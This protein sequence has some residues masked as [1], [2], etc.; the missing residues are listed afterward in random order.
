[1]TAICLSF[2]DDAQFGAALSRALGGTHAEL[3]IHCFPDGESSVR[4][5]ASCAG[6][7][8]I[9][10]GGGRD[11]NASALPLLFAAD[12]ARAM[13]AVSVGLAAPYLPYMRQDAE[14]LPG[15]AVSARA[16]ARFL[17]GTYD[18]IATVD[19]HLHRIQSLG[20]IF[21]IPA[22]C[23]SSMPAV[24]DWIAGNVVDPVIVGPDSESAQWVESVARA[25]AAPWTALAKIRTGDREVSV[26][27]PDPKLI[28]GRSP[29]IVDDIASSG[30]TLA[31][32]ATALRG[33]NSLP[34][35]CVV[36]HALLDEPA[37][38]ALRAAGVA[39]LVSTNTITH[40]TNR[41]DVVPLLA[42]RIRAM[43]SGAHLAA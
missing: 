3:E 12:A 14:F 43:L 26:S 8:V 27:L 16:Y 36:V 21:P 13:G 38:A 34:V 7:N 15:Q 29:V 1:V 33:L 2:P 31:E 5:V 25:L 18:W 24:A 9:L 40:P 20:E 11:P 32:A 6:R 35:T 41:I 4:V 23:V 30:R 28:H 37:A 42:E 39:R 22:L 10:I 19:P 17:S